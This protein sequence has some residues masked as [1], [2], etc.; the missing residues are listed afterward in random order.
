MKKTLLF[1]LSLLMALS[2][3][4]VWAAYGP[5]SF[6][7]AMVNYL[8]SRTTALGSQEKCFNPGEGIDFR[9]RLAANLTATALNYLMS[10]NPS[11]LVS[12]CC[13]ETAIAFPIKPQDPLN[14]QFL[15]VS[16]QYKHVFCSDGSITRAGRYS[17]GIY[18]SL[19]SVNPKD[20]N[21]PDILAKATL[22]YA[23]SICD[24]TKLDPNK[25]GIK[26]A[27]MAFDSLQNTGMCRKSTYSR[28]DRQY[29]ID[30]WNRFYKPEIEKC[31][32][33]KDY[34]LSDGY[35]GCR[36]EAIFPTAG[37]AVYD[38]C[39]FVDE[40]NWLN[41]G[42]RLQCIAEASIKNNGDQGTDI[43]VSSDPLAT[44]IP[45]TPKAT[46]T[47]TTPS[48]PDNSQQKE[49]LQKQIDSI[50]SVINQLTQQLDSYQAQLEKLQAELSQRTKDRQSLNEQINS[51]KAIITEK[52]KKLTELKKEFDK[53]TQGSMEFKGKFLLPNSTNC[54]LIRSIKDRKSCYDK[55]TKGAIDL[56]GTKAYFYNCSNK[57]K[58][59]AMICSGPA[60]GSVTSLSSGTVCCNF[61]FAYF[62]D[63][64]ADAIRTG[65]CYSAGGIS[66][67]KSPT[68]LECVDG[69]LYPFEAKKTEMSQAAQI[70]IDEVK[71]AIDNLQMVVKG[72]TEQVNTL[73]SEI[74]SFNAQIASLKETIK[75]AIA[76]L[77]AKKTELDKLT[78][79][80][81][82]LSVEANNLKQGTA[83]LA[84]RLLQEFDNK[85]KELSKTYFWSRVA[86][87]KIAA[88]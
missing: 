22:I 4:Q 71:T 55:Y 63:N 49:A 12:K 30:D 8:P 61:T 32:N 46:E 1:F 47:P 83:S 78:N 57:Y 11:M 14:S 75:S 87:V 10:Y 56:P 73:T 35:V 21:N 80:L 20:Y 31:L 53:L 42:T 41:G 81:E 19:N 9:G 44:E 16:K 28:E 70:I 62:K 86:G 40:T 38:D 51:T 60:D 64:L 68:K 45:V 33:K 17:R 18:G 48:V 52:S 5:E 59:Q 27:S 36:V 13:G 3:N 29:C 43:F 39:V 58:E 69:N 25:I 50:K 66:R 76:N 37:Y 72:Y 79:Q 74:N 2:A 67:M 34:L 7:R 88:E 54:N 6:S 82:G 15:C 24:N 84:Q 85:I 23:T 77:S 26:Y 65:K